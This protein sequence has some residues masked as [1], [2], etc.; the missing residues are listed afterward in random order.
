MIEFQSVS[1]MYGLVNGVNDV[2]M[3]LE[4][5]A[6]GLLGENGSG[7]TTMINLI[8]GQLRPTIGSVT[9]FGEDPWGKEEMLR[10][11]G[12][13]PAV[14]VLYSNVSAYE[15]VNYQVRLMGFD[16]KEARQ[17]AENALSI[18]GMTDGMYRKIGGYSLGMRQRTK[19]AQAIAHEPELLILDEPYNGLDP[20]GRQSM[21]DLLREMIKNGTSV[22]V[23][24][25]VLHEVE[26][27]D[28]SLLLMV[29]GRMLA[30][31]PPEEI[32]EVLA[33]Q[34]SQ[35]KAQESGTD[36]EISEHKPMLEIFVRSNNNYVLARK[37]FDRIR[38][39]GFTI[40]P[41]ENELTISTT[42]MDKTYEQISQIILEENIDVYEIR[43]AKASLDDLFSSLMKIHRGDAG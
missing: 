6:H 30:Q 37:L 3:K 35:A 10:R 20:I 39:Q 13:C 16:W 27:I 8:T 11:I 4:P 32:H 5:G 7:K 26:A 33:S 9:V 17:R 18:V 15:W 14:D 23:A 34:H 1:K 2:C 38:L 40:S 42:D 24:S 36:T 21:T 25:H 12:L 22:I 19:L 31:G 29:K 41:D 28:P 43:S